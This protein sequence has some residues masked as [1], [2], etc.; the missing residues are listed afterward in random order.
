MFLSE[1]SSGIVQVFGDVWSLKNYPSSSIII[2]DD[3][4]SW[5]LSK[6]GIFLQLYTALHRLRTIIYNHSC[7]CNSSVSRKGRCCILKYS[8]NKQQRFNGYWIVLLTIMPI[9]LSELCILLHCVLAT[10]LPAPSKIYAKILY[11]YYRRELPALVCWHWDSRS[12]RV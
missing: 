3:V 4:G 1:Y 12:K 8:H 10:E 7:R 9:N 5:F 11:C 6:V 2:I